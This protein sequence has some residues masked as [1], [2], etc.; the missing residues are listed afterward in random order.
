MENQKGLIEKVLRRVQKDRNDDGTV[1]D[2]TVKLFVTRQKDGDKLKHP[3]AVQWK[4]VTYKGTEFV[5]MSWLV[6]VHVD[7]L[8]YEHSVCMH[9]ICAKCDD[10]TFSE[11]LNGRQYV[12]SANAESRGL[13]QRGERS[14]REEGNRGGVAVSFVLH[15]REREFVLHCV[16]VFESGQPVQLAGV[17]FVERHLHGV[18]AARAGA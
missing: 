3:Y 8:A 15:G 16:G 11:L 13:H 14:K 6:C 4:R 12:G 5:C 17:W 18:C 10:V 7:T 2:G 9:A 1:N